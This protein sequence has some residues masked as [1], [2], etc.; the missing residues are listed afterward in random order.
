MSSLC[1]HLC[2]FPRFCVVGRPNWLSSCETGSLSRSL[3]KRLVRLQF[4]WV[5]F[6]L[7]Y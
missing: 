6:C 3:L 5:L 4:S 7:V 1:F 2:H